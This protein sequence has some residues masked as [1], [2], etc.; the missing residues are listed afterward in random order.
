MT[1]IKGNTAA[2]LRVLRSG[3][4]SLQDEQEVLLDR[5]LEKDSHGRVARPSQHTDLS[6]K[7]SHA[8][9]GAKKETGTG[10]HGSDTFVGCGFVGSLDLASRPRLF[11][12]RTCKCSLLAGVHTVG[13]G[14]CTADLQW[15]G[16]QSPGIVECLCMLSFAV[17]WLASSSLGLT[18][19]FG[20]TSH[21][22]G[23]L[24]DSKYGSPGIHW[25][26]DDGR[27]AMPGVKL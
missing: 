15:R 6:R 23:L 3:R 13:C 26:C 24:L 10:A 20:F 19:S 27:T 9:S 14:Q 16:L 4:L 18:A 7:A 22:L 8:A 17:A 2:L 25:H 1:K 12:L 5:R 21:P 11:P